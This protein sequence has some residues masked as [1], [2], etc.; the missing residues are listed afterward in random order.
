MNRDFWRGKRVFVTGHTGFKG[1][2]LCLWLQEMQADVTGFSLPPPTDPSLFELAVVAK[3]MRSIEGDIRDLGALTRAMQDAQPDVVLHLAAQPLVRFSYKAPVETYSI[4]VMGTVNLLEAIRATP[5]VQCGV[6]ITTDKCYENK[7]WIWGYR[8]DEPMGGYDPYSSSKGCAELVVSAYRRSFFGGANSPRIASARAGNVIGG[9]DFAEDRLIPDLIRS[10]QA[11]QPLE[12]RNPDA[13]R[14]WQHVLEPLAGYL[15]LAESLFH[16]G[17]KSFAEGWNFGP[18][19][20]DA[21][22]VKKVVNAI[23]GAWSG[24]SISVNYGV[25]SDLHEAKWL[26]LDSSKA[27]LKL[28]WSPVLPLEEG[29]V[30]VADWYKAFL[31]GTLLQEMTLSQIKRYAEKIEEMKN[32]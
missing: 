2:W 25:P 5:S 21:W 22:N 8:E 29:L 10:V 28:G 20:R 16:S 15:Q 32:T 7:E 30:W 6:I 13:T 17:G 14:P 26:K 18:D 4:N 31:N 12:I 1:S 23:V 9:G 24:N 19:D 27:R 11:G 3:G